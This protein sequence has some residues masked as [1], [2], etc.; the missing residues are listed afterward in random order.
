MKFGG[1]SVADTEK[2]KNIVN[3]VSQEVKKY[4]VVVVVI[5]VDDYHWMTSDP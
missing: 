3:I 2:L 4:K 5:A 1:T